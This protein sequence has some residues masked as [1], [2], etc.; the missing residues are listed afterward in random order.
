MQSGCVCMSECA[1]DGM[2]AME[3]ECNWKRSPTYSPHVRICT[4]Y[5]SILTLAHT[6]EHPCVYPTCLP[7]YLPACMH[8]SIHKN[9]RRKFSR[10][11]AVYRLYMYEFLTESLWSRTT[12]MAPHAGAKLSW[13]E[14]RAVSR[15]YWR[16]VW[17]VR[18]VHNPKP[19]DHI[20][21]AS[22]ILTNSFGNH[23][24]AVFTFRYSILA[25]IPRFF[26][27]GAV[28]FFVLRYSL[29]LTTKK[30]NMCQYVGSRGRDS[31]AMQ[32]HMS[33]AGMAAKWHGILPEYLI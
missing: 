28:R 27:M 8:I 25:H 24:L 11:S 14:S 13:A 17:N 3:H 6:A 19:L 12:G 30:N 5:I 21:G 23:I 15:V 29:A 4:I 9:R 20:V 26:R 7:A 22:L 16:W 18:Y 10:G 33:H 31:M 2:C 32:I 1:R